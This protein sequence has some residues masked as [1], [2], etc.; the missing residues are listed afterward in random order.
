M[1][2]EN[3]DAVILEV[4]LGG[5]LDAVNVIDADCTI[6]TG[7]DLDHN[8]LLGNDREVIALEK[9]GII[10]HGR[11]VIASDSDPPKSLL[12]KAHELNVDPW[13]LGHDFDFFNR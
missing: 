6:I 1:S 10:R 8:A 5:R 3:L 12:K 9:A 13:K 11:P 4:K 2:K 7:I